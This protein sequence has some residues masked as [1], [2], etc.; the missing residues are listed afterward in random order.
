MGWAV[1]GTRYS[2][3]ANVLDSEDTTIINEIDGPHLEGRS[4]ADVE[5]I[6]VS[7]DRLINRIPSGFGNFFPNLLLVDW[8]RGNLTTIAADHLEQF[9][10]L[11]MLNLE[12]NSLVS[13]DGD[14]FKPL[15]KLQWIAI[16]NNLLQHAG[17]GLL[18]DLDDLV[19]A[20]FE[21]NPCINFFA[22][23][24]ERMQE[25]RTQLTIQCPPL[26]ETTTEVTT[27]EIEECSVGCQTQINSLENV[28]A[29]EAQNLRNEAVQLREVNVQ[30]EERINQ[31]D[32]VI[33]SYETRIAELERQ[34]REIL[35]SPCM[36]C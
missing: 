11:I 15:K 10:N 7:N 2:C 26:D 33:A 16:S 30:H 22:G 6:R 24:P 14:L 28:I 34:I 4:D 1:I 23:T 9:P 20:H 32:E 17:H 21:V 18:D 27:T 29:E 31:Q 5:V 25:L 13:L 12:H 36:Q 35:S 3:S 19:T 8:F